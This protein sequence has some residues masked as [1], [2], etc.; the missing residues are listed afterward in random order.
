VE[1]RYTEHQVA[2]GARPDAVDNGTW[3]LLKF[4]SRL[5]LTYQIRLLTFGAEQSGVRLVS[6]VPKGCRLSAP[7]RDFMRAHSVLRIERVG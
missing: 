3:C 4:V 7:L 2:R 1:L 5:R 6:R